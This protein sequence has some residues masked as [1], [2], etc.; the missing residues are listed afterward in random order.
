MYSISALYLRAFDRKAT[1]PPVCIALRSKAI[2]PLIFD[3]SQ[4]V[5]FPAD[6]AR[7]V[8]SLIR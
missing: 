5:L 2:P 3:A 1:V 4:A 8:S 6:M 7:V